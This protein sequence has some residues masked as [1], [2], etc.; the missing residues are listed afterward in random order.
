[1]T[2][3]YEDGPV[4]SKSSGFQD[5]ETHFD[6]I[7]P[8]QPTLFE[9]PAKTSHLGPTQLLPGPIQPSSDGGCRV[10]VHVPQA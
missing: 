10:S 6:V 3:F 4:G 8:L 1:M 7:D 5:R 9:G 2:L